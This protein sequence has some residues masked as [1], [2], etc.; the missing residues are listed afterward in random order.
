MAT[1]KF[2]ASEGKFV[3]QNLNDSTV[4]KHTD[5]VGGLVLHTLWLLTLQHVQ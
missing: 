3:T 2:A 1:G 5:K 4:N